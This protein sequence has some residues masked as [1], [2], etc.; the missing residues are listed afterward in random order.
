MNKMKVNRQNS[1]C[2]RVLSALLCAS[3]LLGSILMI[4][5]PLPAMAAAGQSS[6]EQQVALRWQEGTK[7]DL[8]GVRARPDLSGMKSAQL[9]AEVYIPGGYQHDVTVWVETFDISTGQTSLYTAINEPVTLT[10]ASPVAKIVIH[11]SAPTRYTTAINGENYTWEFGIRLKSIDEGSIADEH[12]VLTSTVCVESSY[13]L[14]LSQ[15]TASQYYGQ[16][17]YLQKLWYGYVYS[18]MDGEQRKTDIPFQ[19]STLT[20]RNE[21]TEFKDRVY[22]KDIVRTNE[23]LAKL[24]LAYGGRT[25]GEGNPLLQIWVNGNGYFDDDTF[26]SVQGFSVYINDTYG[27]NPSQIEQA[28]GFK[29]SQFGVSTSGNKN[30]SDSSTAFNFFDYA[31]YGTPSTSIGVSTL[32]GRSNYSSKNK[33]MRISRNDHFLDVSVKNLSAYKKNFGTSNLQTLLA[34]S[35]AP[36]VTGYSM[37]N[38]TYA[39]GDYLYIRVKFSTHVQ[40]E[41]RD[42]SKPLILQASIGDS[43]PID[44]TYYTGSYTDTLVF[45][46]QLTKDIANSLSSKTAI[47]VRPVGFKNLATGTEDGLNR[48]CDLFWSAEYNQNNIWDHAAENKNLKEAAP[49]LY[50]KVDV[51]TPSV[52]ITG[53]LPTAIKTTHTVSFDIE[54]M[55]ADGEI[56]Y[57]LSKNSTS[58]GLSFIKFTDYNGPGSYSITEGQVTGDYYLYIRAVN[59]V[60]TQKTVRTDTPLKFD[61]TAPQITALSAEN[62]AQYKKSHAFSLTISEN[63]GGIGVKSVYLYAE[64]EDG[65]YKLEKHPVYVKNAA[66]N[67]MTAVDD[68]YTITLSAGTADNN[69][70]RLADNSYGRFRIGFLAEDALGNTQDNITWFYD[71][72]PFDTRDTFAVD[73]TTAPDNQVGSQDIFYNDTTV[74]FSTTALQ[75]G[76][77]LT[78]ESV[79]RDGVT[80]FEKGAFTLQD[81]GI[82]TDLASIS[83]SATTGVPTAFSMLF[84]DKAVGRY[85]LTLS[86]NGEQS[87]NILLFFVTGRG[88][89][90]P[91]NYQAIWA[92]DR[93]LINEVWQLATNKFYA[94]GNEPVYYG[95]ASVSSIPIFSDYAHAYAFAE[96]MEYTDLELLYFDEDATSVLESFN[97][98]TNNVYRKATEDAGVFAQTGQTWIRY[99]AST[100]QIGDNS[101]Q[102]WVYYFYKEGHHTAV[103]ISALSASVRGAMQKIS[104][105]IANKDNPAAKLILSSCYGRVNASGEPLYA[106]EAT[107]AEPLTL[108]NGINCTFSP[109]VSYA[110]DAAIY[111][112]FITYNGVEMPLIANYTFTI[113]ANSFLYYKLRDDAQSTYTKAA[114]GMTLYSLLGGKSGVYQFAEFSTNAGYREYVAY[115]DFDEPILTYNIGDSA[116]QSHLDSNLNNTTLRSNRLTIFHIVNSLSPDG[117]YR[118]ELDRYAYVYL[119]RGK[120][121]TMEDVVAYY[122]LTELNSNTG[123]IVLPAGSYELGICDR[124]GNKT[125][126]LI[127]TNSEPPSITYTVRENTSVKFNIS[128]SAAELLPGGFRVYFN[129]KEETPPFQNE[130]TFVKSGT[131]RIE[132]EDI[133]GMSAT[134]EYT[135]LRAYP[136]VEFSYKGADGAY[137]KLKEGTENIAA[138]FLQK[139]N[140]NLYYISS[141]TDLRLRF[142]DS[143]YNY[144]F[145]EEPESYT[146]RNG[147]LD[148]PI[149]EQ[150]FV[151]KI[152]YRNDEDT[153][154]IIT[155]V[156]D[157]T[158]PSILAEAELISY[159]YQNEI[160]LQGVLFDPATRL[161]HKHTLKHGEAVTGDRII[162]TASDDTLLN[163]VYYTKDGGALQTLDAGLG[164]WELTGA[165]SYTVTAIDVLGNKSTFSF[166]LGK[167]L[168]FK[169]YI[170]AESVTPE[171]PLPFL[172]KDGEGIRYTKTDYTGKTI[173][174]VLGDNLSVAFYYKN[175][176]SSG[177][178]SFTVSD[179]KIA[180]AGYDETLGAMVGNDPVPLSEN[181]T[182]S[183]SFLDVSYSFDGTHL[184]LL[185]EEPTLSLETLCIR[186]NSTT[187]FDPYILQLERSNTAPTVPLVTEDGTKVS[188]GA[189]D[190]TG[191]NKVVTLDST[192]L[193]ADL[194]QIIAYRSDAHTTDFTDAEQIV[195][196]QGAD[197][198]A[199]A[200]NGF[201]KIV[202]TNK[203]GNQSIC[204]LRISFGFN[205]DVEITYRDFDAQGYTYTQSGTH[206]LYTNKSLKITL[207]GDELLLNV[208]KGSQP[209]TP[210]TEVKQGSVQYVLEETGVYTIT[211][212]DTCEN[213]ITLTVTV[214][215][216]TPL[217]YNSFLAGF[218]QNALWRDAYYTNAPLSLSAGAIGTNGI[219]YAAY[220]RVGTTSYTRLF[221]AISQEG[222]AFDATRKMGE[223]DGDFE[224]LFADVYGNICQKTVHISRAESLS[225]SRVTQSSVA[226]EQLSLSDALTLGAWSNHILTLQSNAPAYTLTID[227]EAATLDG[228][229]GTYTF[230]FPSALG[231][232]EQR[233]GISFVDAYGNTYSFTVILYRK[234][235]TTTLKCSEPLISM[236]GKQY[237]R[238]D[239]SYD[240][241]TAHLTAT[242]RFENGDTEVYTKGTPLT[243]DGVYTI[244]FTDLAGNTDSRTIIRDSVVSI[245][246]TSSKNNVYDN[247]LTNSA[248]YLRAQDDSITFVRV[249]LDGEEIKAPDDGIFSACGHYEVLV[250]DSIGNSRTVCFDILNKHTK[251]AS[252]TAPSGYALS[253]VWFFVDGFKISYV[254]NVV[255]NDV[256]NQV[257]SMDR[258]GTYEID[259]LHLETNTVTTLTFM[260]DN[261]SPTA[262]LKGAEPG[263]TTRNDVTLE[264]LSK[265]DTVQIYRDGALYATFLS[266]G[267]A[268]PPAI[269]EAGEYHIVITDLAGNT[270]SY[271]FVRA[272]TTNTASNI[273]IILFLLLTA[274]GG[275]LLIRLKGKLRT[276]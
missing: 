271:D 115:C 65:S 214:A 209:Y 215:A 199:L 247:A 86:K 164:S 262:I 167:P 163:T 49:Y 27:P 276:K 252:I 160:G 137:K 125:V 148:I 77:I 150:S 176:I 35:T 55:D 225:L 4:L 14:A 275:L 19:K 254:G 110:G 246:M 227:G 123:G 177:L 59:A 175:G 5:P 172:E 130:L 64:S 44:F 95:G 101:T 80:V 62:Y 236:N 10:K 156:K 11:V 69:L 188:A 20:D 45:R 266:D 162:L 50:C 235:P 140:G 41:N 144:D 74:H 1:R 232:G 84:S 21:S 180:Y 29:V 218:N 153:A 142:D 68:T 233:Y 234:V 147:Q 249:L 263:T 267:S 203:Y 57:A 40:L 118:N 37:A 67:A 272:F 8:Q 60:G 43:S 152:F 192:Q 154:I 104:A 264:G 89:N 182:L 17:N 139:T 9:T 186:V 173:K 108:Q 114:S 100:W 109:A 6:S 151:L 237:V 3:M 12:R 207:Y 141:S 48:V 200:K 16:T 197:V 240:W 75:T 238:T 181:G 87:S 98:G 206:T 121:S 78:V 260:V 105:Q 85:E 205:V 179:G 119:K 58:K 134:C 102:S 244:F 72:V 52:T 138:A 131:Y 128:R 268:R 70:I 208:S 92:K 255:T 261:E 82:I 53:T 178:C 273:F 93:L 259:L 230:T 81:H 30:W 201:Y 223:K 170:G 54:K 159:T 216:P 211:V 158:P 133:Y 224:V 253:Q 112:S 124:L 250:Q 265:G 157:E 126:V 33:Y 90:L 204:L 248:V 117:N 242:Y 198:T 187:G 220:R 155:S 189:S 71:T 229:N 42:S 107:F 13:V 222:L 221:D 245:K 15:N 202:A 258:D 136:T 103:D 63:T 174:L 190:F 111:D 269:S 239:F 184:T 22:P 168:D 127:R 195:L 94:F 7:T 193:D 243:A 113:D 196:Y 18:G 257:Y 226:K 47:T 161:S 185:F 39:V 2:V 32:P 116:V 61:N 191:G 169:W 166:T 132:I 31:A 149:A 23:N 183:C 28:N 145:I 83:L 270:V 194:L 96:V 66:G 165:G 146:L 231:E 210:G 122:T 256:G 25:D 79:K 171:S 219:A 34:W 106:K 143:L 88:E 217:T 212:R 97:N 129:G 56:Y 91:V 38:T 213:L 241:E 24:L 46:A 26:V 36:Y 120:N 251:M 99:K 228:E 135:F 51:R 76:D 274:F 73:I